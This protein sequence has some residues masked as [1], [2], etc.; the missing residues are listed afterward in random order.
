MYP[1]DRTQ[2]HAYPHVKFL[3]KALPIALSSL[4]SLTL[5]ADW[6]YD[7]SSSADMYCNVALD[8]FADPDPVK[9]RNE[10]LAQY[11]IMV[12]WGLYGNPVPAPLGFSDE[13]RMRQTV[14]NIDFSLYVGMN[15]RGV[16]VLTWIAGSTIKNID[17]DVLPLIQAL[18]SIITGNDVLLGTVQLGSEAF[19]ATENVTFQ[20]S[21]YSLDIEPSPASKTTPSSSGS[22][23]S[24][25]S[26][27]S[28]SAPKKRR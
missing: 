28:T 5:K 2:T 18:K 10:T 23:S 27:S 1:V 20:V 9:A 21:N 6:D 11:E 19:Y 22:S 7:V 12:W 26:S 3:S 8:M 13:P 14:N 17:I 25:S 16:N 24:G 15:K 4:T